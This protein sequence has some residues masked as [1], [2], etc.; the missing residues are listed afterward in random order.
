MQVSIGTSFS[1]RPEGLRVDVEIVTERFGVGDDLLG[2]CLF[3]GL[4]GI[5]SGSAPGP[6]PGSK[7]PVLECCQ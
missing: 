2:C 1:S 6:L 4:A 5:S 3:V 7:D